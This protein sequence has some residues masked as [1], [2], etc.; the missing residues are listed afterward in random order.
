METEK[1]TL[2]ERV[3]KLL[4]KSESA[5]EMG[6]QA[7]AE[8][9]AMGAQ[10]MM[11]KYNIELEEVRKANPGAKMQMQEVIWDWEE[12]TNR[13]ESTW[14]TTLI[15]GI[16]KGN[17]CFA[18]INGRLIKVLGQPSNIEYVKYLVDQF[19]V[20]ARH[21]SKVEFKNY[22]GPEKRNT[23]IRGF[24]RGFAEGLA[25]KLHQGIQQE[26]A[27][28]STTALAIR[29]N[30]SVLHDFIKSKY[31]NLSYGKATR[32]SGQGGRAA[33]LAAGKTVNVH[34]GISGSGNVSTTKRLG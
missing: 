18:V 9:F 12:M 21:I 26:G 1:E 17:L 14:V 5:K 3:R 25:F 29:S 7:E 13:H 30:S 32:L 28:E 31:P 4:A 19:L 23:F 6:N 22:T 24:L 20:R 34:R 2:L 15:N 33:G 16:A 10:K 11:L 27:Q 8:A